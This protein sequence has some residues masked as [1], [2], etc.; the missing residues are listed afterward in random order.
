MTELVTEQS[1]E[2]GELYWTREGNESVLHLVDGAGGIS[3]WAGTVE[4]FDNGTFKVFGLKLLGALLE[5]DETVLNAKTRDEVEAALI[6]QC[7][8]VLKIL[9]KHEIGQQIDYLK[10]LVKEAEKLKMDSKEA[11][12]LFTLLGTTYKAVRHIQAIGVA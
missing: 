8:S 1:R 6:V 5:P 11:S 4:F 7:K 10:R 12:E 3:A 9:L 2:V